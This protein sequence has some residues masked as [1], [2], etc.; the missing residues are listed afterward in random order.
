MIERYPSRKRAPGSGSYTA[1]RHLPHNEMERTDSSRRHH[2]TAEHMLASVPHML[3]ALQGSDL[4]WRLFIL[5][6]VPRLTWFC[7]ALS[8]LRMLYMS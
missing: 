1:P 6:L 2:D 3:Q 5:L 4:Q 7:M 8:L